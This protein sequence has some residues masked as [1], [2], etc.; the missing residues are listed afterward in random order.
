MRSSARRRA[1]QL[2]PN[3]STTT[4][5]AS[6]ACSCAAARA[7]KRLRSPRR[8]RVCEAWVVVTARLARPSAL[9]A[10]ASAPP[11]P[12]A[13][14]RARC[15]SSAG[16]R[17]PP[18]SRPCTAS[19]RRRRRRVAAR[20]APAAPVARPRD[21]RRPP[22]PPRPRS[23]RRGGSARWSAARRSAWALLGRAL[24]ALGQ[25]RHPRLQLAKR[26]R[27]A[28]DALLLRAQRVRRAEHRRLHALEPLARAGVDGAER[29]WRPA[30]RFS[31]VACH[32]SVERDACDDA[33][34]ALSAASVPSSRASG[35]SRAGWRAAARSRRGAT[36]TRRRGT[37]SR[38]SSASPRGVRR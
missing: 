13:P 14:R 31:A 12:R 27:V 35:S 6:P 10:L 11:P 3:A 38:S 36:P 19:A 18:P 26:R 22:A 32:C 7:V 4:S 29:A 23:P 5:N 20:R 8:S 2:R 24:L 37:P 16:S 17:A 30:S 15:A 1:A 9:D 21:A 34:F 25:R 33:A 28:R